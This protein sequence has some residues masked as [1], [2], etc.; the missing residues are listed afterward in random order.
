MEKE[1]WLGEFIERRAAYIEVGV[2]YPIA[3]EKAYNDMHI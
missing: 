2:P 1:K 3:A